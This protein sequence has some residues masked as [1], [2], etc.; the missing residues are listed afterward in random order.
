MD[1][2]IQIRARLSVPARDGL[3][4]CRKQG[5]FVQSDGGVSALRGVEAEGKNG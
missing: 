2:G 4:G 1:A 3:P 5:W